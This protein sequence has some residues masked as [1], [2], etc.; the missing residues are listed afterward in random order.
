MIIRFAWKHTVAGI[1]LGMSFIW[2][3]LLSFLENPP[4]S[5]CLALSLCRCV[6]P[7]LFN[8]IVV[9]SVIGWCSQRQPERQ[10]PENSRAFFALSP[11]GIYF[12]GANKNF[13]VSISK[14]EDARSIS[15]VGWKY[16]HFEKI[17]ERST[18]RPSI[19]LFLSRFCNSN[20]KSSNNNWMCAENRNGFYIG[21]KEDVHFL[22]LSALFFL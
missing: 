22:P 3:A 11:A 12:C 10:N 4:F 7:E 16:S 17:P 1:N 2:W 5:M 21:V 20:T 8:D 6:I 18:R 15:L 19:S 14:I 13:P 9:H